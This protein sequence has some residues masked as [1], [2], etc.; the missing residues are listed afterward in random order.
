ML[1]D[2]HADNRGEGKGVAVLSAIFP[3]PVTHFSSCTQPVLLTPPPLPVL[4]LNQSHLD[5][6]V[7]QRGAVR[8]YRKLPSP[9][10]LL[11]G[12]LLLV[13]L[14]SYLPL[15]PP[16]SQALSYVAIAAAVVGAPPIVLKSVAALRRWVLDINTL[17]IIAGEHGKKVVMWT[18]PAFS[19]VRMLQPQAVPTKV[20]S[21]PSE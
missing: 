10:T 1:K 3:L 16:A 13:S 7:Q 5:A 8:S 12:A 9:L 21:H 17:M 11:S 18:S 4:L 2:G 15:P 14:L 6:S 20:T 19:D